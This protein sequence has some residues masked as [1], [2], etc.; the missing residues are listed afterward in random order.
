[1]DYC[2][3][4]G[5]FRE[6]TVTIAEDLR[7]FLE[8]QNTTINAIKRVITNYKKFSKADIILSKTRSRLSDL[9]KL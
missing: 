4:L 3:V 7:D 1:V 9:Q 2:P 8:E 5:Y 6:F